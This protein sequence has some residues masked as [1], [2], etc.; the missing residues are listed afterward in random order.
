MRSAFW[1]TAG[2]GLLLAVLGAFVFSTPLI[3]DVLGE[4]VD[5]WY[6]NQLVIVAALGLVAGAVSGTLVQRRLRHRP[7]EDAG[8]FL[9]RVASWGFWTLMLMVLIAAV[10]TV[11][12][13]ATASFIPLAALNRM[14]ELA[15]TA[16]FFGVLGAGLATAALTYAV[17]TRGA[18][19]GGRFALL[20]PR[21]PAG[22]SLKHGA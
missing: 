12:R 6:T 8:T 14:L 13:A 9:S 18:N 4:Q 17:T 2:L 22:R 15:L 7:H 19:W 3:P 20:P 5:G 11:A 10:I 16:R 1:F 21:T